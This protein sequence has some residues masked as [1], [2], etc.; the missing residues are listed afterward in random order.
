[1]ALIWIENLTTFLMKREWRQNWKGLTC[2]GP[3]CKMPIWK[4]LK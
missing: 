3:T 2:K 1:M 4:V